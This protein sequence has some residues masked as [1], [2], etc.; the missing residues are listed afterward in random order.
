[1]PYAE[2]FLWEIWRHVTIVPIGAHRKAKADLHLGG[3]L[4]PEGTII[5]TALYAIHHDPKNFQNPEI[6]D[7]ERFLDNHG[8]LVKNP[9]IMP[10]Q[11]DCLPSEIKMEISTALVILFLVLLVSTYLSMRK[12]ST[13]PPGPFKWPLVGTLPAQL[14]RRTFGICYWEWGLTYGKIFSIQV[15]QLEAVVVTDFDLAKE[16]N[17]KEEL[18]ERPQFYFLH[19]L[20]KFKNAGLIF[21]N[22]QDWKTRRRFTLKNLRDFGFGK[23]SMEQLI[24]DEMRHLADSINV[25]KN[26][27]GAIVEL[28]AGLNAAVGNVIWWIAASRRVDSKDTEL[29]NILATM[30]TI[31]KFDISKIIA[32]I[33]AIKPFVP[34]FILG[35]KQR[36]KQRNSVYDY[37]QVD[38]KLAWSLADLFL[39]GAETTAT[40]LRWTILYLIEFPEIQAKLH[41]EIDN[42]TIVIT[43]LYAIH[44]DPKNFK[45]P[46]IFHPERFL[47]EDGNLIRNPKIMPFQAGKRQCLGETLA[48]MNAFLGLVYL[49]QTFKFEKV[50]GFHYTLEPKWREDP[51]H[52]PEPYKGLIDEHRRTVD[53]T[54]PRDLIDC[55]I[56]EQQR[57]R[58]SGEDDSCFE[59]KCQKSLLSYDI[60]E[61]ALVGQLDTVV[62][63]DFDLAKEANAKEEL[64]D[65][66]QFDFVHFLM[67]YKNA[68]LIFSNGQDWKTRRRFTLKNLRDFGFGK[69]SMEQLIL[70]EMRHLA[71]SINVS[72]NPKGAIVELDAGLNAAVGNVIWWITASR[73]VD[74]KDTELKNILETIE[75][76]TKFDISKIIAFIPAIK[77]FVPDFILGKK[78]RVEQRNSV[79]DYM[80][81][82]DKLAWSLADLFIAGAETTATTLR[83]TI[84]YLIEFPEIQAKLHKE[85]DNV[86]GK[87]RLP[88]QED[89]PK[90]VPKYFIYLGLNVDEPG[91]KNADD[92]LAWSLA[93]LFIAGAETTATT[94]RWTIF[95]E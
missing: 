37:M 74:S 54:E 25:S 29:K 10:F 80:Q 7:P 93:D 69:S 18:S 20:M 11:A 30:E 27:T 92:K 51:I 14:M 63:T 26:P 64:S 66:P 42:G 43:A 62:L 85:I 53:P 57:L 91:P 41:K 8:N 16:A 90:Q 17:A 95:M 68:G 73:R 49:L 55:C 34:D 44:H 4:I 87:D 94:L 67:K 47:D 45:N 75:T 40:T 52:A 77:P 83:W 84:L 22:G 60:L 89:H 50:P 39:A 19:F 6:F 5:T 70:D 61:S 88:S 76:I 2:A 86:V 81:V 59:R 46:E 31:A 28:D 35:R 13:Y 21:S 48:R 56:I 15:G 78:E 58:E 32:F 65:R 1:M 3:Y 79:Y 33:P 9:K 23:S 72:K 71:D 36:L 82:D 24:L 12:P 38:D